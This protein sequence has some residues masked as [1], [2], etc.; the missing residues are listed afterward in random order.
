MAILVLLAAV[1]A[2]GSC[3]DTS[4]VCVTT[5]DKASYRAG[6]SRPANNLNL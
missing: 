1:A 6:A 3:N 4:I 5:C 2:V